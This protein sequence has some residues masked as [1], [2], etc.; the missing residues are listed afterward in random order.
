MWPNLQFRLLMETYECFVA[1][2]LL[3]LSSICSLS[4][5]WINIC[6]VHVYVLVVPS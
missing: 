5:L 3:T 2:S 6:F 1:L 4:N